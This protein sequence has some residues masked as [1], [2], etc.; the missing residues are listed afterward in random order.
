MS[1]IIMCLRSPGEQI[2]CQYCKFVDLYGCRFGIHHV[3]TDQ[4]TQCCFQLRKPTVCISSMLN[5]KPGPCFLP[6]NLYLSIFIYLCITWSRGQFEYISTSAESSVVCV[7]GSG[8]LLFLRL[9]RVLS[10]SLSSD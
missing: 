9:L 6:I 10:F 1:G 8:C 4:G 2:C 7:E 3:K 5:G